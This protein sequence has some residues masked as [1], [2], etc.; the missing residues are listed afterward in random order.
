MIVAFSA[1]GGYDLWMRLIARHMEKYIAGNPSFIV[2]NMPGAGSITAANYLSNL[3]KPDGLTLGS[4]SAALYFDQLIGRKEV[5]FDWAK[6]V[7]L[8]LRSEPAR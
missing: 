1:G 6:L 7:G 2:Q 5:N 3:A 8:A 4:I